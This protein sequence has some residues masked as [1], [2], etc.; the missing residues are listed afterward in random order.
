MI[1]PRVNNIRRSTEF[2]EYSNIILLRIL[3]TLDFTIFTIFEYD[4]LNKR[5]TEDIPMDPKI[6]VILL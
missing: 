3:L 1:L 2:S 4:V 6:Y 5:Y